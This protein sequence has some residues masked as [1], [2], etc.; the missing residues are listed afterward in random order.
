MLDLEQTLGAEI[1]SNNSVECDSL[2]DNY[3]SLITTA[4]LSL[5]FSGWDKK[6]LERNFSPQPTKQRPMIGNTLNNVVTG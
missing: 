1:V 5:S 3:S 4:K 2:S 6:L